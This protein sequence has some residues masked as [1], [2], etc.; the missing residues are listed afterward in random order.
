[1]PNGV[2]C[3]D[4]ESFLVGEMKNPPALKIGERLN[5]PDQ[6]RPLRLVEP[7]QRLRRESEDLGELKDHEGPLLDARRPA[8]VDLTPR[9]P[10][11]GA[12]RRRNPQAGPG[13]VTQRE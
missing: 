5:F 8:M 9:Q 3:L 10:P 11:E 1:M 13:R 7:V 6:R 12:D 4:P 2:E